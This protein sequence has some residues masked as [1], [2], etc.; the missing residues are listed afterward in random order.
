MS[1]PIL[2]VVTKASSKILQKSLKRTNSSY[3]LAYFNFHGRAESIRYLL[4]YAGVPWKEIVFGHPTDAEWKRNR[5]KTPYKCLPVLYETAESGAELE[6]SEVSPIERYLARQFRI[7]G[8]DRWARFQVEQAVSSIDNC[9]VL[10]HYK[11]LLSNWPSNSDSHGKRAQKRERRAEEANRFYEM[12]LK[13][14]VDIHE[15][16]LKDN[17]GGSGYYVGRKTTLAD[18]RATLLIDRLLLLR[19]EGANPVPLSKEKTP[20]LWKVRESV[21]QIPAISQWRE[22]ARYQELDTLTKK[23]FGMTD[24]V[25]EFKI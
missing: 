1:A 10:Y 8:A 6:F 20:N 12:G 9:Q 25:T 21:H 24:G 2:P 14:F 7:H 13:N 5:P 16:R 22:S 15:A 23:Y 11:V 17:G 19:P 4:A 18:L 3:Q